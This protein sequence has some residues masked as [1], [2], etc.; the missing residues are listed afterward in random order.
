M[1]R[2]NP[3]KATSVTFKRVV[4]FLYIF[5]VWSGMKKDYY[6]NVYFLNTRLIFQPLVWVLFY[7]KSRVSVKIKSFFYSKFD[8]R[9]RFLF[10]IKKLLVFTCILIAKCSH[11]Q[12]IWF[13]SSK[14]SVKTTIYS[15]YRLGIELIFLFQA[16][17]FVF[18]A[19]L[20]TKHL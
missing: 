8:N 12:K 10:W 1:L 18:F 9:L 6:I 14:Y 17:F 2:C 4:I 5:F 3:A 15:N 16:F 13:N 11:T 7:S 20:F 19:P